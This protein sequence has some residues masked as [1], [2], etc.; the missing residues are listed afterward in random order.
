VTAPSPLHAVEPILRFADDEYVGRR[1]RTRAAMDRQGIGA[2][3]FTDP[4]NVAYFTGITTPSYVIRSR[5]V[6]LVLGAEGEHALICSR[7][8]VP[9]FS[10][11][12]AGE[13]V[14]YDGLENSAA[15]ALTATVARLA[16]P[17][18]A[19]AMEVGAEQRLNLS[20]DQLAGMRATWGEER[21]VD[22]SEVLWA[23]RM[24]KSPG[25][26]EAVR[27]SN[28]VNHE[29]LDIALAEAAEHRTEIGTY[30]RWLAE[31]AA[32][33]ADGPH[34]LGMHTAPVHMDWINSSPTDRR[35]ERGEILWMDGGPT[36]GGYWSDITRTV[37][38]DELDD[39]AARGYALAREATARLMGAIRAGVAASDVFE[40]TAA[41][42]E[43]E[44]QPVNRA[45][46]VGHGIGLQ[47]TEAPSLAPFDHTVLEEGMVLAVEP[48]ISTPRGRFAV[49]ENLVVTSS[50][51]ELLSVPCPEEIPVLGE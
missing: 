48:V 51:F 41:F 18:S 43:S 33:G 30:R 20:F 40:T 24:R 46:R 8:H 9:Y 12:W 49:E 2:A 37:A 44:G 16:G 14:P 29:S 21:V 28:L 27:R 7:G 31:T 11:L 42:L 36:I 1:E 34:Y 39:E 32:R 15:E 25:E 35:I 3:A 23:A 6:L 38:F 13:L 45:G 50:G 17:A 4:I 26:I 47:L 22:A 10:T 5:P 19:V